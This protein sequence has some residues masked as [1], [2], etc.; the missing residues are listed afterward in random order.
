MNG[1]DGAGR[2]TVHLFAAGLQ[3]CPDLRTGAI[4]AFPPG[5]KHK[6]ILN[7]NIITHDLLPFILFYKRILFS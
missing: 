1:A 5:T 2:A 6:L 3:N 7:L 4:D